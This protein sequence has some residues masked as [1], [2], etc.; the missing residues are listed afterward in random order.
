MDML[1]INSFDTVHASNPFVFDNPL[2]DG[3]PSQSSLPI[4]A[5]VIVGVD[6]E[7]AEVAPVDV[8]QDETF[9]Q[10]ELFD[11]VL[12]EEQGTPL[13]IPAPN[14]PPLRLVR[15]TK[16]LI[17]LTTYVSIVMPKGNCS[18][19]ISQ[20]VSYDHLSPVY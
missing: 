14:P 17:W 5:E 11:S 3:A 20:F 6:S 10:G 4:P 1:S 7:V 16:P 18:H 8:V 9:V 13:L 12:A 19:P 2:V 15:T